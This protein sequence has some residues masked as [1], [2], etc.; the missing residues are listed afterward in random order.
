MS[1]II[2]HSVSQLA[3]HHPGYEDE[4]LYHIGYDFF[5]DY[6]G[7]AHAF[8]FV[9]GVGISAFYFL[10]KKVDASRLSVF[11][12]MS[13]N[14]TEIYIIQWCVIGFVDSIFCYFIG[15]KFSYPF[16]YLFGMALI[17]ISYWIAKLWVRW[18]MQIKLLMR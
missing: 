16:I 8:M 18:R 13:R 14:V 10:L 9:M 5:G 6:L 11:I 12:T 17:V 7:V 4:I 1:M 2:C 3:L 15:F